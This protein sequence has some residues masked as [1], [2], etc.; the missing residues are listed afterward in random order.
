MKKIG[1]LLALLAIIVIGVTGCD[2]FTNPPSRTSEGAFF[3]SQNTG[4]FVNGE[5]K[6]KV[7]PDVAVLSLGV[8]AR[9]N[10]VSEA[11]NVASASMNAI[12]AELKANGVADKDIQTTV[13]NI[14]RLTRFDPDTQNEIPLGF[15]VSN[16]VSVKIRNVANTGPIIDAVVRAG[17]DNARINSIGFTMDDPKPLLVQARDLAMADAKA[18]AEQ[19]AKA[20]GV[21]VGDPIYINESGG[22]FPIA[23]PSPVFREAAGFAGAP[24]ISAG[25][26]EVT[27]NVQVTYNIE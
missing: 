1:L 10:T 15:M 8:E 3:N 13:F 9:A 6:V 22:F 2:S 4:L 20:A 24:P 17:G 18:K 27:L 12:V 16:I 19:L 14:Q 11:Q 23:A 5:G 25:E 7:V 21:K 26:T